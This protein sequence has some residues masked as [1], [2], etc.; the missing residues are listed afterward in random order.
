M[1][2]IFVWFLMFKNAMA[3]MEWNETP[4]PNTEFKSDKQPQA[5]SERHRTG[6]VELW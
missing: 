5:H 2:W 3:G 6:T 1:G 4:Q